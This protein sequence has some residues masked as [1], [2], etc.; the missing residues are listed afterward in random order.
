[1]LVL[2]QSLG[3][4]LRED[5]LRLVLLG[6]TFKGVVLIDHFI[7][8][9]PGLLDKSREG[10]VQDE[11]V[12]DLKSFIMDHSKPN[13]VILGIPRQKVILRELRLPA[14]SPEELKDLITYELEK[15]IPLPSQEIY[16]DYKEIGDVADNERKIL[17]GIIKKEDLDYYLMLLERAE[18]FPALATPLCYA[19][20]DCPG[21]NHFET[22]SLGL[23]V[24]LGERE[25]ELE[26]VK[27]DKLLFSRGIPIKGNRLDDDFIVYQKES[28]EG[29]EKEE[30]E[31]IDPYTRAIGSG[32]LYIVRQWLRA[33]KSPVGNNVQKAIL[34]GLGTYES[35]LSDYL[36][37][38]W[39][40]DVYIPNPF[41]GITDKKIPGR[42]G[43]ALA[44]ATGLAIKGLQEKLSDLNLLPIEMRV[45]RRSNALTFSFIFIGLLFLILTMTAY[46]GFGRYNQLYL[47]KRLKL[48]KVINNSNELQENVKAVKMV[49]Q[50]IDTI[51]KEVEEI[52]NLLDSRVSKLDILKE[53]SEIIPS[54]A[55]LDKSFIDNENI[56]INGY[57]DTSSILIGILE[58]SP[59]FE[60]VIFPSTI[61]KGRGRDKERF[62]IKAGIQKGLRE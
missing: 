17:L 38:Q 18:L 42:K 26:L 40:I 16:Y 50:K 23:Q 24:D 25:L 59:F 37:N 3:I 2:Q 28:T 61:T 32:V 34:T 31:G 43:A 4:D 48:E 30:G 52:E 7:K 39:G 49:S 56:E 51:S 44:M 36:H 45:T 57:A 11:L 60:N 5:T 13:D 12:A 6:K 1:M 35:S 54:E 47:P 27:G 14:L 58:D 55:W 21:C 19:L 33:T 62:R 29:E 15:H 20:K 41:Q 22:Q 53:L 10:E 46:T 8:E 9:Y